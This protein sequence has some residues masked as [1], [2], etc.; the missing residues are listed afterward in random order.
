MSTKKDKVKASKEEPTSG[1]PAILGVFEGE[2]ADSNITN[3]NGLDMISKVWETVFNSE[4][5]KTGIKLGHY[6]GFL[7]HPADVGDQNFQNACIVMIEGHIDADGIVYGKF[8]LID[9][10]VG[11]IVKTFIDAGVKFGISVRGVGDVI[12]NSVD[13]E[14]FVF[15]G[16]DLVAFPAFPN[17]IPEFT[18]LAASSDAVKQSQYKQICASVNTNLNDIQSE[19]ALDFLL[20]QF[21]PQS[22]EHKAITARKAYLA[23]QRAG[24]EVDAEPVESSDIEDSAN[25]ALDESLTD[26]EKLRCMT[27][28]Y[29]NERS[30]AVALQAEVDV[31]H[32]RVHQVEVDASRRLDAVRRIT[33]SQMTTLH[34]DLDTAQKRC[35]TI[36]ASQRRL[37]DENIQLGRKNLKYRQEIEAAAK[38]HASSLATLQS[39]LDETVRQ[40]ED[41]KRSASNLGVQIEGLRRK[42]TATQSLLKSY[43]AAYASL[44]ARAVG[45]EVT[46]LPITASTTVDEL[47]SLVVSRTKT[48][49]SASRRVDTNLS[50]H[51]DQPVDDDEA[52]DGT[53]ITV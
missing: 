40:S 3:L 48:P 23:A 21:A 53:L 39:Q 30:R 36:Q 51:L 32:Q 24:A 35:K 31:L 41:D 49:V 17:S 13:P 11:R 38:A 18:A 8:N 28:M 26:S 5:F 27:D 6:L 16:F 33:A 1:N 46:E 20:A 14:T 25:P 12:N 47:H 44:Y 2:C 4:E 9:T 34:K 42:V 19:A 43:Q 45:V 15:R 7:G 37:K 22:E 50:F 52:D 29:V 10:P